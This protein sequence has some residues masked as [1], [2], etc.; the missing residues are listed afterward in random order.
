MG[1][2]FVAITPGSRGMW[3]TFRIGVKM[4]KLI[5]VSWQNKP[6]Y[7]IVIENSWDKL[8]QSL[9]GFN[10]EKK[11]ICIVT[12]SN[13]GPH[14]A[15]KV[16]S[17]LE[18]IF[19]KVIVFEFPAGE[20]SKNLDMINELYEV[21]IKEHFDRN[22]MLAALGGGVTGDM[23]GFAA[24]TYLRGIDFIQLPTSL[25][26]QVDSSV[27]GKTG[28]DFKGYK[29]MVGAFKQPKLVYINTETLLTLGDREFISGMGEVIKYGFIR[30]KAFLQWLK[31]NHD[32]IMEKKHDVLEEMVARS[33]DFKRVV[34][35]N[36]F[37]EKGERAHLNFGHTIGHSIEKA[38]NFEL[39]HGECVAI[40]M[41]SALKISS[42]MGKIS[43]ED[44]EE[45]I[46]LIKSFELPVTTVLEDPEEI[47]KGILNDKKMDSGKIKFILLNRVGE[48]YIEKNLTKE[49]IA[50]GIEFAG[51]E[52]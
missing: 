8:N 31:E 38:K 34:V 20:K 39:L 33:C 28:V 3:N 43:A 24:A 40:G 25:L 11:K 10:T 32:A 46:E 52:D 47:Y 48:A 4:S 21:L 27:G 51:N 15:V 50:S 14:F 22:D 18:K 37:T 17:L 36:D 13:V 7:D 1:G 45:G 30:D 35:E 9:A 12:E 23:T 19:S 41:A 29:N 26:S 42:D 2:F 44:T 5:N 49:Q 16:R 6:C